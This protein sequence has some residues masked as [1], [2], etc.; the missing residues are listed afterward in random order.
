MTVTVESPFFATQNV[1]TH[2]SD[3]YADM[4][5]F[6]DYHR[7]SGTMRPGFLTDDDIFLSG[8]VD[9]E[10]NVTYE[11]HDFWIRFDNRYGSRFDAKIIVHN[12]AGVQSLGVEYHIAVALKALVDAGQMIPAYHMCWGLFDMARRAREIGATEIKQ[13]FVNGTLKKK[14]R[15]NRY[16]VTIEAVNDAGQ[17][18]VKFC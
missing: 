4:V 6:R 2:I 7:P 10:Q 3:G 14:R 11:S 8:F 13:A 17:S 5:K 12:G 1:V 18:T 9:K 16:Y 15:N